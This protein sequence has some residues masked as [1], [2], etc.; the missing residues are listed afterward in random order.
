[1]AERLTRAELYK[2]YA[3]AASDPDFVQSDDS[4][5]HR[6]NSSPPS[7]QKPADSPSLQSL[8][9]P[10]TV[11]SVEKMLKEYFSEIVGSTPRRGSNSLVTQFDA[12]R[13][14]IL[15][16]FRTLE[17]E[18]DAL[19]HQLASPE[20]IAARLA[21]SELAALREPARQDT[22][23][24]DWLEEKVLERQSPR[25]TAWTDA[26]VLDFMHPLK[27]P[28]GHGPTLR[29]AIDMARRHSSHPTVTPESK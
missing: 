9:T 10:P 15:S 17:E 4:V 27:S 28:P 8:E 18:R 19:K 22:E 1:M 3:D 11:Q 5:R 2:A 23:R 7:E 13:S 12:L 21:A 24:L 25:F 6:L 20:I 14:A 26:V 29:E 16:A